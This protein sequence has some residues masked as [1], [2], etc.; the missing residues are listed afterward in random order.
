MSASRRTAE[1]E[2]EPEPDLILFDGECNVCNGYVLFV[3]ARDPGARFRFASLQSAAG[4]AELARHG[5]GDVGSDSIVLVR[6]GRVWL[7]T[8]AVLRIAAGLRLPWPLLAVF[9]L[10]PPPLRDFFYKAFAAR[11]YRWFG[12]VQQC[13]RPTPELRARFL[14]ADE[15]SS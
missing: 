11:R 2:P 9:L 5:H 8:S 13:L 1:P 6:G 12:R 10:V 3:I 7:R 14:D 15:R 4:Q